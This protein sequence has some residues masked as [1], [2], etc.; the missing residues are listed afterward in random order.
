MLAIESTLQNLGNL[1]HKLNANFSD[2]VD[3]FAMETK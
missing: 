3:D 2:T 1:K